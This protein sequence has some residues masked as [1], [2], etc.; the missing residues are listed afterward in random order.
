VTSLYFTI[1]VNLQHGSERV[2]DIAH[3]SSGMSPRGLRGHFMT[4]AII[5]ATF[6]K[7]HFCDISVLYNIGKFTA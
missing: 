1:L 2:N 3:V 7:S 4:N 6:L 5:L